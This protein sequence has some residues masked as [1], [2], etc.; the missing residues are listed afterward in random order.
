VNEVP[1]P[2]AAYA[3]LKARIRELEALL[4]ARPPY[5]CQNCRCE[6]C[7]NTFTAETDA[8]AVIGA[9]LR[10]CCPYCGAAPRNP[11]DYAYPHPPETPAKQSGELTQCDG[12]DSYEV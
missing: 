4:A 2:F 3:A 9:A 8:K 12:E 10:E 5:Y 11:H 1:P 7:G 6:R